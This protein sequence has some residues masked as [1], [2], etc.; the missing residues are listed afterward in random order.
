MSVEV[1]TFADFLI[2]KCEVS[3]RQKCRRLSFV[4]TPGFA[5]FLLSHSSLMMNKLVV[6]SSDGCKFSIR[7]QMCRSLM[8]YTEPFFTILPDKETS[9]GSTNQLYDAYRLNA[10]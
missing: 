1:G 3:T 10:R 4:F 6:R 5:V 2:F 7:R 8:G 9:T